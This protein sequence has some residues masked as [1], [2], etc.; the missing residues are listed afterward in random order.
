MRE[1]KY[2]T[3]PLLVQA[4]LRLKNPKQ[5]Q[6]GKPMPRLHG[7]VSHRHRR[8]GG[9]EGRARIG[10]RQGAGRRGRQS[11]T[12][13]HQGL[14]PGRSRDHGCGRHGASPSL[15][16]SREAKSVA[17]MIAETERKFGRLYILINNAAVGSNILMVALKLSTSRRGRRS[18]RSMSEARSSAQGRHSGDT[19]EQLR[20]NHQSLFDDDALGPVSFPLFHHARVRSPHHAVNGAGSA[21][22]SRVNT[23]APGLVMNG[24]V[25]RGAR[26]TPGSA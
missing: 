16:M 14:Q 11:R 24:F 17:A 19:Q 23:L 25:P 10:I 15:P 7:K 13:R 18:C 9:S 2:V 5:S 21:G 20:E 8:G 3:Y 4:G 12:R 26:R 6:K 22:P 1:F